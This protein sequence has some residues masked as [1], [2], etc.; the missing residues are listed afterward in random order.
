MPRKK[1]RARPA[2]SARTAPPATAPAVRIPCVFVA[3]GHESRRAPAVSRHLRILRRGGLVEE[4]GL[5]E[6]ARVRVYRLR[7]EPFGEL[8]AW[9]DQVQAFWTEQLGA[10]KEHAERTSKGEHG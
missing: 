10:F 4:R 6:D 3:P 5:D 7:R 9:L 8:Q 1:C 2:A